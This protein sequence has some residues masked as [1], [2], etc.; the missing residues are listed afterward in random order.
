MDSDTA[1]VGAVRTPNGATSPPTSTRVA[2][3]GVSAGG[4]TA[5]EAH[6]EG[7]HFQP[8]TD[9]TAPVGG[10]SSQDHGRSNTRG[11]GGGGQSIS[12]PRGMQEKASV[13]PS[14]QEGDLPSGSMPGVP[15]PAV[16]EGTQ[17]QQGGQLR[18]ALLDPA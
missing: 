6:G 3:H 8:P 10:A 15:P 13:Q 5:Q 18:S 1:H 7:S 11:R 17:P 4:T 16:P 2:S 9:K 14:H 12:H